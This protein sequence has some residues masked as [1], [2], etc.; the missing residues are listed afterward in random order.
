MS[1]VHLPVVLIYL[2]KKSR[3]RHDVVSKKKDITGKDKVTGNAFQ[4]FYEQIFDDAADE[5]WINIDDR[6]MNTC[7]KWK[8][9]EITPRIDNEISI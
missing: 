4:S 2:T 7:G 9:F 3:S 6:K 8:F 5:N 1:L